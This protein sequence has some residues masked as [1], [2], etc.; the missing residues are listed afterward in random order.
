MN[1]RRMIARITIT[2]QKK[3]TMMLGMAYP[4]TVLALAMAASYP[5]P[6]DLFRMGSQPQRNCPGALSVSPFH[7]TAMTSLGSITAHPL[8]RSRRI[9]PSGRI[10]TPVSFLFSPVAN[11]IGPVLATTR[12]IDPDLPTSG[13]S[14][15]RIVS[16]VMNHYPHIQARD[17]RAGA[18]VRRHDSPGR[19]GAQQGRDFGTGRLGVI[20]RERDALGGG[21]GPEQGGRG[22]EPV[23]AG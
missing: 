5:P 10:S 6:P 22:G 16:A 8:S 1:A 23:G 15:S 11:P 7:T 2:N 19:D 3:N 17:W 14:R 12:K 9:R 18:N 20:G 13:S 4:A 21:P